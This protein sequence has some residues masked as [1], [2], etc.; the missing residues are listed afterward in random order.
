M[1]HQ[2]VSRITR[3]ILLLCFLGILF[4]GCSWLEK[5]DECPDLTT[6]GQGC[7]K[8]IVTCGTK[9]FNNNPPKQCDAALPA[10]RCKDTT[11]ALGQ[12]ECKCL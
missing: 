9:C 8:R 1:V 6:S 12:C 7:L 5:K 10:L 4:Q 11:N 3:P 2:H